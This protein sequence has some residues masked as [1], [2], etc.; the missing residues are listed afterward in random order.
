M[1]VRFVVTEHPPALTRERLRHY[2]RIRRRLEQA[3]ETD[4]TTSL[5]PE[6]DR[7]EDAAA[8]VL[9]GSFA[10]WAAHDASALEVLG[11][12]IR[13]Y[14]GAVLGI[15]AGMQLQVQFAGGSIGRA[16]TKPQTG[17][18][19]VDVVDGGDLLRGL[20]RRISVYRHH[21]DE[22]K[23]VPAGF[24]VLARSADCAVEAI[25]APSRGWWGTQFHPEEFDRHHPE[26]ARMLRNFFELAGLRRP[27]PR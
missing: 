14:G 3:A 2:D 25:G 9:S 7:L 13:G 24:T 23:D 26:G 6:V 15:C 11:D 20:P 4:V 12:V 17:Y 16:A 10:P 27:S 18:N 21:T 22:V 19:A 8:V 5:Y 1:S